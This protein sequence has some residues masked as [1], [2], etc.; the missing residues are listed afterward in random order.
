[1]NATK[2]TVKITV[3]ALSRDSV[4]KLVEEALIKLHLEETKEGSLFKDDGDIV[5]WTTE[6]ERVKF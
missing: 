5:Y 4:P 3:E 6:E 1:M 2:Y